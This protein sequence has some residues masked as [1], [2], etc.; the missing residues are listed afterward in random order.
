MKILVIRLSSIGDVLLTTPVI[1]CLKEQVKDAEV[2]VL[3][4][5]S[6][7]S[8]LNNNPNVNQVIV[9]GEDS[10]RM[11][12]QLTTEGYDV[13]IDLH[14]NIR[15][16]RI[17][18]ALNVNAFSFPKLNVKKWLLVNFKARVM[19]DIHIV[20]RYFKAVAS[21]GVTNDGKGLEYFIPKKDEVDVNTMFGTENYVAVA[22]G[23]QFATKVLPVEKLCSILQPLKQVI[24]LL[25]GEEDVLRAEAVLA[26]L[27]DHHIYSV[28]GKFNLNQS[29]DV[30]K[31]ANVILTHDTGLMHIASAFDT[32]IVSVWGNT[33]PELGMYP[34]RPEA[35]NTFTIHQVE[36][37]SCRPCSKIGFQSCPKKHFK[38]M[39]N[40][41]EGAISR[42]IEKWNG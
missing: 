42:E 29:A 15:S 39:Q 27:S 23:A 28:C 22:M 40:Q 6:Y 36:G 35:P 30:V 1:R 25:G 17:C 33:V 37:L 19:P 14:K 5:P 13:V 7:I 18:R 31:K 2:H 12:T 21:L 11:M 26:A 9:Y 10:K 38:C 3:T 8:M 16:R 4:K 41:D 32:P 34:Y 24:V 20:D